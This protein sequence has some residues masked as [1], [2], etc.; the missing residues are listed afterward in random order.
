MAFLDWLKARKNKNQDVKV[1]KL[2]QESIGIGEMAAGNPAGAAAA[3]K[4]M[5]DQKNGPAK[6]LVVGD[7]CF[8]NKL[9]DYSLKMAQR[10][11]CAIVALKV[12]D[13][14]LQFTNERKE[15]ESALFYK[16]AEKNIEKHLEQANGLG[17]H[18]V[19]IMEIGDQERAISELSAKD[20]GIRY[21]LTEPDH[22]G[23]EGRMQIP[24]FDL[25]CS[26]L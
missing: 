4:R 6:I 13:A 24:V 1:V 14:P 10:L 18:V 9:S 25:A 17:V 12:S 5:M 26:R 22:G 19:H 16:R 8:S 23:E 11:D 3:I 20:P 21:V 2:Q 7:G 15:T